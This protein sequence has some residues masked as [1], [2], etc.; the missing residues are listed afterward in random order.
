MNSW[1]FYSKTTLN[2]CQ[3]F[4]II[5]LYQ[6]AWGAW[7]AS[8]SYVKDWNLLKIVLFFCTYKNIFYFDLL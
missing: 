5:V 7:F 4:A 1:S 8:F 3:Q 6:F 2:K